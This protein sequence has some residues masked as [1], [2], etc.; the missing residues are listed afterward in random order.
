MM[1]EKT[2]IWVSYFL[3]FFCGLMALTDSA[4]ALVLL[5]GGR[6]FAFFAFVVLAIVMWMMSCVYY[7]SYVR[8]RRSE[9][10]RKRHLI[11]E[12]VK[13]AQKGEK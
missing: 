6:D 9:G 10:W 5:I 2:R 4:L 3:W 7:D 11:D 12:S 13:N 1:E 8:L